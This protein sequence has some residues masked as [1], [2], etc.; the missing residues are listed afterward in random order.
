M[1]SAGGVY[2][3]TIEGLRLQAAAFPVQ[4]EA[5]PDFVHL[6]DEI[7]NAVDTAF[8]A[9]LIGNGEVSAESM[10]ALRQHETDIDTCEPIEDYT[11]ALAAV[12]SGSWFEGLRAQARKALMALDEDCTPPNLGGTTYV[13]GT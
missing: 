9:Q 4:R 6:P 7:L 8:V 5:L 13:P 12:E 10:A 3:A 2:R 11:E 1:E